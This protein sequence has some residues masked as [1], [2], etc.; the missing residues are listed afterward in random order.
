MEPTNINVNNIKFESDDLSEVNEI[1]LI[2]RTIEN[3]THEVFEDLKIKRI[4]SWRK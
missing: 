4:T 2:K 3:N 1:E